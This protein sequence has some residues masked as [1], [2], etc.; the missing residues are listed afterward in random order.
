MEKTPWCEKTILWKNVWVKN[1]IKKLIVRR[2]L[3]T[4]KKEKTC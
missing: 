4:I 2:I 1:E 3:K